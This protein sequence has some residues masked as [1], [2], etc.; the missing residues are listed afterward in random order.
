MLLVA[1]VTESQRL[2][3]DAS[4][5]GLERLQQRR[6]TLPAVTHVDGSA[7]V[8]TVSAAENPVFDALLQRFES[9]TGCPVLINTSFN[10]RG[11]PVVCSPDDSYRCFINSKM[12]A[13]AIGSFFLERGRQPH[14]S[15]PGTFEAL[16]D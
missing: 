8:Q 16:P 10:V 1:P 12:D 2:P 11:E 6:S 15:L 3:V 14:A 9:L 5:T 13:L 4:V 7:R